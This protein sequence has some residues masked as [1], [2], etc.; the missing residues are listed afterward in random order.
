[1]ELRNQKL[2]MLFQV[3]LSDDYADNHE[4]RTH[5]SKSSGFTMHPLPPLVLQAPARLQGAVIAHQEPRSVHTCIHSVSSIFACSSHRY[6]R[7]L[8]Q[9]LF[10]T[11]TFTAPTAQWQR[12]RKL[13]TSSLLNAKSSRGRQR[14][15][16][17]PR[18]Q[19][20]QMQRPPRRHEETDRNPPLGR[21]REGILQAMQDWSSG[22]WPGLQRQRAFPEGNR[23]PPTTQ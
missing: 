7:N 14:Y 17:H 3:Y 13:S 21:D 1:M 18:T 22:H 15:Q 12:A 23:R 20:L 16:Q 2:D 8:T 10:N 19:E 9:E 4:M 11:T 5:S 6:I